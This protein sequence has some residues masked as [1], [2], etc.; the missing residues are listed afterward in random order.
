MLCY[1][2][3]DAFHQKSYMLEIEWNE[4]FFQQDQINFSINFVWKHT[5]LIFSNG[6]QKLKIRPLTWI[7]HFFL[8]KNK[9]AQFVVH[10][11]PFNCF[12]SIKININHKKMSNFI[13]SA[14]LFNP[15]IEV[16][17]RWNVFFFLNTVCWQ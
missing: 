6:L 7:K 8:F 11:L 3:A 5:T 16:F 10:Q 1:N 9:T 4:D 13:F 12:L 15:N 17:P 14:Y 2:A